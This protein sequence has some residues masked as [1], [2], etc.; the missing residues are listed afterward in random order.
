MSSP[1]TLPAE[2]PTVR[3]SSAVLVDDNVVWPGVHERVIL[4][5]FAPSAR[6]GATALEPIHFGWSSLKPKK[7]L[8]SPRAGAA[9]ASSAAQAHADAIGSRSLRGL[10]L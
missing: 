7:R 5:A 6:A 9:A 2:L 3:L 1:L 8:E 4:I 10:P